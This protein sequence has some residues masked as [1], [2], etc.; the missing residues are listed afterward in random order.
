MPELGSAEPLKTKL[1]HFASCVLD[2]AVEC[3]ASGQLGA[4]VTRMLA[5]IDRSI[6]T[7][8]APVM[9]ADVN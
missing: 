9:L 7:N 3:I 8:G 6:K 5:A 1:Q 4:M 2:P